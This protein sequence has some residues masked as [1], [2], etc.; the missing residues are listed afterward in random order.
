[1]A[2]DVT[3]G[4]Y[5][6]NLRKKMRIGGRELSRKIGIS[7]SYLFN[8]E[9]GIK[10]NPSVEVLNKIARAFETYGVSYIEVLDEFNKILNVEMFNPYKTEVRTLDFGFRKQLIKDIEQAQ[11]QLM[12][13]Y[14]VLDDKRKLL[15]EEI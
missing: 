8:L 10:S 6:Y 12:N 9:K 15:E 4:E 7:Q 3:L 2:Q 13:S 14:K 11:E 1:M 5:I